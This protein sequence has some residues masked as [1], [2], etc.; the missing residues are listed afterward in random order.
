MGLI[1][2]GGLAAL[3]LI[4][5]TSFGTLLIP[6]WIMLAGRTRASTLLTYL[7]VV[8][9]F[10]YL[11][12]LALL[13]GSQPAS[14]FFSGFADDSATR[15]AQLAIGAVLVFLGYRMRSKKSR[16]AGTGPR[17]AR[18]RDRLARR[19]VGVGAVVNVALGATVLEVA[20]MLPYLG[21][22]GIISTSSL[23]AASQTAVLGFYVAVM[24]APALTLLTVRVIFH[25]R[26]DPLLSRLR[27]WMERN[28]NSIGEWV[29]SIVGIILL[30]DG[31]QYFQGDH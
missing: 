16:S 22:L 25:A 21:A 5:S 14:E 11:L 18:F 30:M 26:L 4:D 19:D 9:G 3:A 24:V 23:S 15:V 2:L 10:Y 29:V 8:A 27:D 1:E 12:G 7:G 20:T 6:L 28:G 13:A 31:I 17:V